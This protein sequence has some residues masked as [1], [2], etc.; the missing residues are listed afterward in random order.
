[1]QSFNYCET[2]RT[3]LQFPSTI[4]FFDLLEGDFYFDFFDWLGIFQKLKIMITTL[5]KLMGKIHYNE[6]EL[7]NS[8]NAI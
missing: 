6:R 8:L 5:K 1:M 3:N 7:K 2:S 4:D